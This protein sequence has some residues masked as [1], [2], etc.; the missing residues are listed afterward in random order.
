MEAKE[1]T[2]YVLRTSARGFET[3]KPVRIFLSHSVVLE[4]ICYRTRANRL[5]NESNTTEGLN[6]IW[7]GG[8]KNDTRQPSRAIFAVA[9]ELTA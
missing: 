5:I 2:S 6:K 1:P 3:D 9:V 8:P 7:T 4:S